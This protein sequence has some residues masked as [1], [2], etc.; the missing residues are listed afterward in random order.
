MRAIVGDRDALASGGFRTAQQ[1]AWTLD[2]LAAAR[3]GD[4]PE[5]DPL[6]AAIG[7][8]FDELADP[9]TYDPSRFA[10]DLGAL[11]AQLP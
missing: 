1:V 4:G 2:A 5:R 3:T 8:L 11:A 6:R 9:A 7:R 10:R